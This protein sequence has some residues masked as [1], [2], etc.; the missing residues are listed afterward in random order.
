MKK[1]FTLCAVVAV[2]SA[3]VF[4]LRAASLQSAGVRPLTIDTLIDIRHPSSPVWSPDGQRVAFLSERAGIANIFVA[5]APGR[6][7]RQAGALTHAVTAFPDGQTGGFFWS[8]DSQRLYFPRQGD[9]WQ[10]AVAGGEPAAVWS[11]P[12]A[13]LSIAPSPDGTR[14]AFVRPSA[15]ASPVVSGSSRTGTDVSPVVSG[16]SR[17]GT[18]RG[19][20]GGSGGGDLII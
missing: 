17:T 4:A 15:D 5:D 3:S 10:V 8:A 11:T 9:L 7:A 19:G 6:A 18:G 14:V 12:Q 20:R 1:L 16:L 2:A 13:E